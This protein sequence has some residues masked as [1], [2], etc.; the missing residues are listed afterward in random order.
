MKTV[1]LKVAGMSCAHCVRAISDALARVDG[2]SVDR[3]TIGAAVV[4]FDP[5]Q[6]SLGVLIDAVADA[7]YEAEEVAS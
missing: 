5:A 6:V 1:E 4:R 2:V 3:V 7:G